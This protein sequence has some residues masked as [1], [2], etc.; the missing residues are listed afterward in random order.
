MG[1]SA[2]LRSTKAMH[3][4][5]T[6]MVHFAA[7]ALSTACAVTAQAAATAEFGVPFALHVGQSATLAGRVRITLTALMPQGKC[8]DEHTE[9][10]A[11][12]PPQAEIDVEA[13]GTKR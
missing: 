6:A 11:V 3:F 1:F 13:N 2:A 9:C 8:P 12:S 7:M 5:K 10:V 4:M